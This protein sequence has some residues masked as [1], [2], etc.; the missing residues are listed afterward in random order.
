MAHVGTVFRLP[1]SPARPVVST[2][3]NTFQSFTSGDLTLVFISAHSEAYFSV[4]DPIVKPIPLFEAG[5][6]I[7]ANFRVQWS[8][9]ESPRGEPLGDRFVFECGICRCRLPLELLAR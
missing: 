3:T 2:P 8:D 9:S 4:L 7:T 6:G 1:A 5:V